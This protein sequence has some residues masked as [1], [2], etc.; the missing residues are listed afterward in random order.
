MKRNSKIS[1]YATQQRVLN[2]AN[3]VINRETDTMNFLLDLKSKFKLEQKCSTPI[4]R[5]QK[6]S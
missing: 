4:K 6:Y 1:N 5:D 2:N 3:D